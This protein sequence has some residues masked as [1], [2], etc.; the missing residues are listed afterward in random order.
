MIDCNDCAVKLL[1]YREVQELD[2]FCEHANSYPCCRE[3]LAPEEALLQ[4][5]RRSRPLYL[6][7]AAFRKRI[8][9]IWL[10]SRSTS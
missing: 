3:S 6:A 1:R 2:E 7:P 5:L 8:A 9:A 4:L 10:A